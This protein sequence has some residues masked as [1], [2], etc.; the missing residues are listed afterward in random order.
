MNFG[1]AQSSLGRRL[2]IDQLALG[3]TLEACKKLVIPLIHRV[4]CA[5]IRD[6]AVA[7]S[8]PT[9]SYWLNEGSAD[10]C[11]RD[12]GQ[13]SKEKWV[14]SELMVKAEK[15]MQR[16]S[17]EKGCQ[18]GKR[19]SAEKT[20]DNSQDKSEE[21]GMM[22]EDLGLQKTQRADE[23]SKL[24]QFQR[25]RIITL[26]KKQPNNHTSK[27]DGQSTLPTAPPKKKKNRQ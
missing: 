23:K 26:Q 16:P 18:G 6:A 13:T 1:A 20:G 21:G 14:T 9:E 19:R 7:F 17:T 5:S 12:L 11:R 3:R 15:Y 8:L 24:Q 2:R 10:G 22:Q 27:G 4:R 25:G